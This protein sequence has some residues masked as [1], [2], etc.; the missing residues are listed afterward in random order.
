M[1]NTDENTSQMYVCDSIKVQRE[2]KNNYAHTETE[3][4]LENIIKAITNNRNE[5]KGK[6]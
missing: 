2:K 6:E 1:I 3:H 5:H 4:L